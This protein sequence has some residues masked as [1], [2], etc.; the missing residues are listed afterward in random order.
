MKPGEFILKDED[1]EINKNQIS[2]KLLIKNIGDRPIQVGSHY[3]FFEANKYLEFG[4]KG[5]VFLYIEITV[6]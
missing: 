1:I 6:D 3:H 5:L 4:Y 2:L